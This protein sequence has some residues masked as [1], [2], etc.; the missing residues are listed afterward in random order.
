MLR[1]TSSERM[2]PL[3]KQ[4]WIVAIATFIAVGCVTLLLI[5]SSRESRL[6]EAHSR[7][8]DINGIFAEHVERMFASILWMTDAAGRAYV[9]HKDDS[10]ALQKELSEIKAGETYSLQLSVVNADGIFIASNVSAAGGTDLRDRDHVKVHL[11]PTPP[12]IFIS[13]PLVGRVSNRPSINITRRFF[14]ADGIARGI[15]V[16]SYDPLML[17][18]FFERNEF[19]IDGVITLA[20]LDGTILARSRASETVAGSS[21]SEGIIF[22][23]FISKG[24]YSGAATASSLFD[25]VKRI[26]DFRVIEPLALLLVIGTGYDTVIFSDSRLW[27]MAASWM[28][29]LALLLTAGGVFATKYVDQIEAAQMTLLREGEAKNLANLLQASFKSTGVFVIAF[30]RHGHIEFAN[31]VARDFMDG[32]LIRS[33][34][35]GPPIERVIGPYDFTK[36]AWPRT[37][38]SRIGTL[39]S[40]RVVIFWSIAEAAWVSPQSLVAIG[41]D[42]TA[43]EA[44]ENALHQKARLTGLGEMATGLAHEMAQP[45]TVISFAAKMVAQSASPEANKQISLLTSAAERLTRTVE[46]MKGFARRGVISSGDPFELMSSIDNACS[47]TRNSLELLGI[48]LSMECA[49]LSGVFISG[50]PVLL[51]QVLLNLIINARDAINYAVPKRDVRRIII[52]GGISKQE[53]FV[54]ITVSDTGPGL[55]AG[56]ATRVFEPFFTTK[57]NGSGLGLSLS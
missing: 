37:V 33:V 47:L 43:L 44:S 39:H 3:L 30:N 25:G 7:M 2:H 48:E 21:M 34:S 15:A 29:L 45:L 56:T 55:P 51:E 19:D 6:R 46:R 26:Y 17:N 22:R 27:L 23:N 38:T 13:K 50:D 57:A 52:S 54:D 40:N 12:S 28:V 24:I 41:F 8:H 16:V 42:R 1:S 36:D 11:G 32:D 20:K 49:D 18:A 10:T 9:R 35:D 53:S 31:Q 5:W 4:Y 14:D